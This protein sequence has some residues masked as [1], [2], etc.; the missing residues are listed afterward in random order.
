MYHKLSLPKS[1]DGHMPPSGQPQ[2]TAEEIKLIAWWMQE[3]I[4]KDKLV[5]QSHLTP[6][7]KSILSEI[8]DDDKVKSPAL[9][10]S[11]KIGAADAGVLANL[12]KAGIIAVPI[13]QNSNYL[14]VVLRAQ[15]FQKSNWK[16]LKNIGKNIAWLSVKHFQLDDTALN[17]MVEL[18]TW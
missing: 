14:N 18:I 6:E 13:A 11:E 4:S 9:V 2:P 5:I 16:M 10:P 8:T 7:I 1:E 15:T 17:S 3:D 12:N